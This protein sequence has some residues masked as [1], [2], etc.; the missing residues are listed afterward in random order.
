MGGAVGALWVDENELVVLAERGDS[1]AVSDALRLGADVRAQS[2]NS[3]DSALI[4]AAR[5][6]D[7]TLLRMLLDHDASRGAVLQRNA[8]N[9]SALSVAAAG[10]RTRVL[11]MLLRRCEW[12]LGDLGGALMAACSA[13][14]RHHIEVMVLH[15]APPMFTAG[16]QRT[17]AHVAAEGSAARLSDAQGAACLALLLD[18]A[19]DLVDACDIHGNTALHVAAANGR[20]KCVAT[21]LGAAVCPH[22][23]GVNGATPGALAAARPDSA[24]HR[25]CARLC[26]AYAAMMRPAPLRLAAA[27]SLDGGSARS[28]SGSP[29]EAMSLERVMAIWGAFFSNAAAIGPEAYREFMYDDDPPLADG[30]GFLD[31]AAVEWLPSDD[32]DEEAAEGGGE[33]SSQYAEYES[34]RAP[35]RSDAADAAGDGAEWRTLWDDDAAAEYYFNV[36]T[37]ASSWRWPPVEAEEAGAAAEAEAAGEGAASAWAQS[38]WWREAGAAG[39]T[40]ADG[41]EYYGAAAGDSDGYYESAAENGGEYDEEE[42]APSAVGNGYGCENA[43][44]GADWGGGGTELRAAAWVAR[45]DDDADAQYYYSTLTNE[46]AREWPAA[47]AASGGGATDPRAYAY[48]ATGSD[49]AAQPGAAGWGAVAAGSSVNSEW[50][51]EWD[52]ANGR[53]FFRSSATGEARW[54]WEEEWDEVAGQAFY[55]HTLTGEAVWELPAGGATPAPRNAWT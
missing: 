12:D 49:G 43:S 16:R 31:G 30:D 52:A 4:V 55:T 17:A 53:A 7:V 25:E 36:R 27:P 48:G 23:C 5:R 9:E 32:D 37:H 13:G 18:I 8:Q 24:S 33:Y 11:K 34:A 26:D 3:G 1:A 29:K 45:W 38:G 39:G 20:P 21:L 2:A 50:E 51:E 44:W 42:C 15:G 54:K 6:G 40:G 28:G 19:D 14:R 46:A 41:S 10:S 47:A 35:L 22:R